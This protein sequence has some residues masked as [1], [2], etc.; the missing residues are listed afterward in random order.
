MKSELENA[1]IAIRCAG[2]EPEHIGKTMNRIDVRSK[3]NYISTYFATTGTALYRKGSHD[4]LTEK[5]IDVNRF[6]QF[7]MNPE[8]FAVIHDNKDIKEPEKSK[9]NN[10]RYESIIRAFNENCPDLPKV[11]KIT[12][13]RINAVKS[14]LKHFTYQEVL[15][16]FKKAQDSS[17]LKG[18]VK[19]AGHENWRCTFDWLMKET[20]MAKVLDGNYDNTK[21]HFKRVKTSNELLDVVDPETGQHYLYNISNEQSD[22]QTKKE[23]KMKDMFKKVFG[24]DVDESFRVCGFMDCKGKKC[25]SCEYKTMSAKEFWNAPYKTR[26]GV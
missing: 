6:I 11:T 2:F 25:D 24:F 26:E 23:I 20:N 16:A 17:F 18:E 8:H 15:S 10:N 21:S 1:V 12:P 19:G 9:D 22:P 5:N 13:I 7:L 4:I 14:I 3:N